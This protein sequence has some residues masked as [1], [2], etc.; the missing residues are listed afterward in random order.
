MYPAKNKLIY[1]TK[2]IECSK[3]A[4]CSFSRE[5]FYSTWLPEL[6]EIARIP[7]FKEEAVEIIK[8]FKELESL[9][10]IWASTSRRCS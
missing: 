2:W 8:R 1:L 9:G 3:E 7:K 6:E 10:Q 4:W 5:D